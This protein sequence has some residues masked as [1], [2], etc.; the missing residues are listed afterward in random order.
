MFH[1]LSDLLGDK[2]IFFIIFIALVIFF[3]SWVGFTYVGMLLWNALLVTM[4][5]FPA[6]SFWGMMGIRVLIALILPSNIINSVGE[7]R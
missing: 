2:S 5:D 3:I 4:F 7:K 1:G 6:I